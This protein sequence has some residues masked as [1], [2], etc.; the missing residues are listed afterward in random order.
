[1]AIGGSFRVFR[2][3]FEYVGTGQYFARV[4]GRGKRIRR[5]LGTVVFTTRRGPPLVKWREQFRVWS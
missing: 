5:K 2:T 4:K 3:C 1:M